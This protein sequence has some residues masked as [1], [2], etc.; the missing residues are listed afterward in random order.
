MS[1][2]LITLL[3]IVVLTAGAVISPETTNAQQSD[4]TK[5]QQT[6]TVKTLKEVSVN[7][8]KAFSVKKMDRVVVNVDA[9]ISNAGTSALDVL[10]KSPGVQVDQNGVVSLK[11]KQG[12]LIFIDDKPT[13]LAADDLQ[14]YLKSLPSSSLEQIEIMS[15]PPA[16]YD[17]AGG[18]GVINIRTKKGTAK[19]FNGALNLA[20]NQGKRTRLPNSLNFNIRDRK[21]NYYGIISDTYNNSFTDLDINR[22]YKNS[23]NSPRSFF[24]QNSFFDRNGNTLNGKF[25]ADYYQSHTTTWGLVVTGMKRKST[26]INNNTSNLFNANNLLD[27]I[28]TANNVDKINF[29][30]GGLNFNYRHQF[31]STGHG[32]TAD[33]DYLTY[34]NQTDQTYYN[35]SYFA[36]G[37]LKSEDILSGDLPSTINIYSIKTDYTL[38]MRK[39]WKFESGL[40][41]SYTTTDNQA[42]YATTVNQTTKPDYDKSNHFLFQERISAAY[43]N[44][45]KEMK[46]LSL[47]LGLRAEN[48]RSNGHQLG[49]IMKRDS[50]FTKSYTSIFP[51]AYLLYKL[52]S[53]SNHQIGLNYGRRIERPYYQD[54]NPF[55]SPLDKFT[56]YVG[57]PFLKPS[58]IQSLELSYTL[59]NKYT[60]TS[61]YSN[62]KDDVNETIEITNGT[63]YSRPANLGRQTVKSI[64]FNGDF[65]PFKW[66]NINIYSEL[67]NIASKSAFYTGTLNTS[68]TYIYS[69]ANAR[70]TFGKGWDG[71]L[72][73]NYRNRM[74]SAQFVLGEIWVANVALQKKLSAKATLKL[75]LNDLF[76]SQVRTGVINNLAQTEANWINKSDT[77]TAILSFNYRFGKTFTS[78]A[79]HENNGADAEKNRVKG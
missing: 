1:S 56:Y 15:N 22:T 73:G 31:D 39:G 24:N 48:T 53:A 72:S 47:Q 71:E 63:Y 2:K 12:V 7:S 64:S 57:N 32:I 77:R 36:G 27:S 54:L 33:A 76:Y 13:Y 61:S 6:D 79:K 74:I 43:I 4:N 50:T 26:Q 65:N 19:G 69:N 52:D 9:L 21:M 29:N 30:N 51:T 60:L 67:T 41:T 18:A 40:K 28:I 45:S 17:A 49:N 23:D 44:L 59:K 20:I 10:E 70:I 16:R 35:H 11:G 25:G 58:Y 38:P 42:G 68:G 66:L 34:Q 75:S 14:N 3:T 78:P 62:A 5:K 55:L 46:R 8:K 37:G